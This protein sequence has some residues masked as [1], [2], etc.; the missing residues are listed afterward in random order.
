M[1]QEKMSQNG[2]RNHSSKIAKS[3]FR[4]LLLNYDGLSQSKLLEMEYYPLFFLANEKH[5]WFQE[6][7]FKFLSHSAQNRSFDGVARIL[8]RKVG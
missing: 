3:S 7:T 2:Q 8:C 4:I 5:S 6:Y 1:S